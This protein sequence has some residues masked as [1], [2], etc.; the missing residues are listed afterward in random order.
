[1]KIIN[2]NVENQEHTESVFAFLDKESPDVICLQ[3]SPE[4]FVSELEAREYYVRFAPYLNLEHPGHGVM[5]IGVLMASL[6]PAVLKSHYYHAVPDKDA[7]LDKNNKHETVSN[8]LVVGEIEDQSGD[9]YLIATTHL[10][11]TPDGLPNQHQTKDLQQLL[12]YTSLLEPHCL[13]GDFN[14]PRHHNDLY[15]ELIAHYTDCIPTRY[16][17]SLDRRLHRK[18]GDEDARHMFEKYMV[19]YLFTQSPYTAEKVELIF[20]ISDHAAVVAEVTR[21]ES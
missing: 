12:T 4:S 6:Q 19:D 21:S 8:V 2:L 5:K 20:G 1:M 13:L 15:E 16:A 14:I 18:G 17:S 11:W 10:T 3:E 7:L 9:S